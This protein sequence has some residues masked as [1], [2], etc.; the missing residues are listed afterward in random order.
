MYIWKEAIHGKS[1]ADQDADNRA[2][3]TKRTFEEWSFAVKLERNRHNLR[4]FL[5]MYS[6]QRRC[7]VENPIAVYKSIKIIRT[8]RVTF[9]SIIIF[10]KRESKR[11][12]TKLSAVF[13]CFTS[14]SIFCF[15]YTDTARQAYNGSNDLM[16]KVSI[17]KPNLTWHKRS[18]PPKEHRLF[19]KA[20]CCMVSLIIIIYIC[21]SEVYSLCRR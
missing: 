17:R 14:G 21:C 11:N 16:T 8:S 13:C 5:L 20:Q 15:Q 1:R 12:I 6:R 19:L 3:H 18:R 2:W 10:L 7:D 9:D 4:C